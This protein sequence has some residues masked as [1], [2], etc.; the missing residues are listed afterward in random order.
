MAGGPRYIVQLIY[1]AIVV[2]GVVLADVQFSRLFRAPYLHITASRRTLWSNVRVSAR[3][4]Q[5]PAFEFPVS[6]IWATFSRTERSVLSRRPSSWVYVRSKL[7]RTVLLRSLGMA[8][9]SWIRSGPFD[10]SREHTEP[11]PFGVVAKLL[12]TYQGSRWCRLACWWMTHCRERYKLLAG[13][14][15]VVLY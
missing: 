13:R 7:C 6:L 8:S 5:I 11:A 15:L 10:L 2:S 12:L 9:L 3:W 4:A 1:Y 14:G